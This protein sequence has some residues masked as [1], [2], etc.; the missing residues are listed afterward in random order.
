MYRNIFLITFSC[1][2]TCFSFKIRLVVFKK[3]VA[4]TKDL[5]KEK[6]PTFN[7]EYKINGKKREVIV[8]IKSTL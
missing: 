5:M 4:T 1:Y 3:K 6:L 7:S 2:Y 8:K